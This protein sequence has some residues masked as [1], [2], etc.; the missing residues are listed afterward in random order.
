MRTG[1]PSRQGEG[2]MWG[3]GNRAKR[4]EETSEREPFKVLDTN[5]GSAEAT[6]GGAG[7]RVFGRS[8]LGLCI[9]AAAIAAAFVAIPFA[10]GANADISGFELDGNVANNALF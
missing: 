2:H 1:K 8:L 3:L 5:P 6:G 7:R 10:S 9:V 4:P